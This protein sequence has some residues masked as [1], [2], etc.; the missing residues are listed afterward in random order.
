MLDVIVL[1][2]FDL[3]HLCR[4]NYVPNAIRVL[5]EFIAPVNTMSDG[6]LFQLFI[7]NSVRK[8][9]RNFIMIISAESVSQLIS[10]QSV[11]SDTDTIKHQVSSAGTINALLQLGQDCT[12]YH[13]L[14]TPPLFNTL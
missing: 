7:S 3:L 11:V 10:R 8:L 12:D 4:I 1:V 2:C 9:K 13:Q 14:D 5:K 6:M